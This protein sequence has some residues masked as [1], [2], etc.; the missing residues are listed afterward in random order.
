[1]RTPSSASEGVAEQ[2]GAGD[3]LSTSFTGATGFAVDM[4]HD[5]FAEA[6]IKAAFYPKFENEKCDQEVRCRLP[7]PCGC[8]LICFLLD[9]LVTNESKVFPEQLS[10][11]FSHDTLVILIVSYCFERIIYLGEQA[12]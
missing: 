6:R 2:G 3:N 10:G 4:D 11:V 1:M 5:T 8:L 7:L 9:H 12:K